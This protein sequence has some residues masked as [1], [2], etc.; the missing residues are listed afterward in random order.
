[1]HLRTETSGKAGK[2]SLA[3]WVQAV[4]LQFVPPSF[5]PV[6]L[7]AAMAWARYSVFDPIALILVVAGVTVHHFGLNMLDDILDHLHAVDRDWGDE[8]NP[9]TG[10]SGVLT[11]GLLSVRQ[12]KRGVVFCYAFTIGIWLYLG[13]DKGWPV[14]G[15]GAIG[16]LSSIFYTAPPVKFAYRGFGELG[17]LV[18]FGPVLVLGS[19]YVQRGTLDMEPLVVSFVPGFLMWSMIVINEIPDYEEDRQSGK[20]TLVARFGRRTGVLLYEAGLLCAFGI[21]TGSIFFELAPLPLLLGF[22]ALPLAL[23]SVRLL[24]DSYLDRLKMIPANL[25]IIKVYLITGVALIAGYLL[26]GFTGW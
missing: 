21:L 20:M 7:A 4:R 9:Y 13:Y 1:M 12:L 10:G 3:A 11:E 25:A 26:H 16:I 6:T 24:R 19:Y 2:G 22:V 8:K 14:F 23:H 18:N 5:I 17:L 15:I